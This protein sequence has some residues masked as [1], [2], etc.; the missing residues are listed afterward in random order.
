M[1]AEWDILSAQW[2][3]GVRARETAL[4]LLFLA[5]YTCSEP[6]HLTGLDEAALPEGLIEE[7]FEFLGGEAT[8]D[9]EFLFVVAVMADVAPWCLGS[10]ER[11]WEAIGERF[12][13]RLGGAVP[14]A[15]TFLGRGEYGEYF[16]M[17][18]RAVIEAAARPDN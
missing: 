9:A 17:Q 11:R 14:G 6:V 13:A 1:K 10:N 7:L 16:A 4:R 5:W 15:E 8:Q 18:A 3:D 12:W 2:L